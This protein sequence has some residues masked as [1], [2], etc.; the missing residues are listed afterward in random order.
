MAKALLEAPLKDYYEK[1]KVTRNA[2]RALNQLSFDLVCVWEW[3]KI[4]KIFPDRL[5]SPRRSG[6]PARREDLFLWICFFVLRDLVFFSR[7]TMQQIT[8][9]SHLVWSITQ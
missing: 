1:L 5:L 3:E 8:R 4:R 9:G 6:A 7:L 2:R